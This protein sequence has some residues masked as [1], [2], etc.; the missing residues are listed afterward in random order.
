M[1]ATFVDT[2]QPT[3]FLRPPSATF[4][5]APQTFFHWHA[6]SS[7]ITRKTGTD[8]CSPFLGQNSAFALPGYTWHHP[9]PFQIHASPWRTQPCPA[10]RLWIVRDIDNPA[11]F[12]LNLLRAQADLRYPQAL[13]L[14]FLLG[15]EFSRQSCSRQ[16]RPL[17]RRFGLRLVLRPRRSA[18]S[19]LPIRR[20]G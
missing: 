14:S 18:R 20:L 9:L 4:V 19:L 11:L 7:P 1:M 15:L 3:M 5:T 2:I 10:K 17:R 12:S 13:R 16:R 6:V 8:F